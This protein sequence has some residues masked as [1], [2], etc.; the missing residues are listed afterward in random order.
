[1][2]YINRL[3]HLMIYLG[4]IH[5]LSHISFLGFKEYHTKYF[6]PYH[7]GANKGK[8]DCKYNVNV[9]SNMTQQ[10][11]RQIVH[12]L[13]K[14]MT[15]IVPGS[16]TH[17]YQKLEYSSSFCMTSETSLPRSIPVQLSSGYSF[18]REFQDTCGTNLSFPVH[19]FPGGAFL[20]LRNH[21]QMQFDT[22]L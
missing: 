17:I 18:S 1:M 8:I 9:S 3:L 7:Q 12:A 2:N 5:V 6:I 21:V 14:S 20:Q 16:A 13:G 10:E 22:G 4:T 19:S 11:K 15:L